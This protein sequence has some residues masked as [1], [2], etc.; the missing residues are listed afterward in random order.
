MARTCGLRNQV[1]GGPESLAR[2][3]IP[4]ETPATNQVRL[5][6]FKPLTCPRCGEPIDRRRLN[7]WVCPS[8]QARIGIAHSYQR[9]VDLLTFAWIV[10]L[11][12]VTHRSASDGTWLLGI[13]LSAIPFWIAFIVL[14][15]PWLKQGSNQPRVT[16]V[17]SF[18][19][20]AM[21]IFLVEFLGFTAVI[22]LL[23]SKRDLQEHLDMLSWPLAWINPNFLIT[24]DK[25]LSDVCG[26]ILGNSFFFGLLLFAC[27][28][29]VRWAFRRARVQRLWLSGTNPTDDDD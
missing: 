24:P 9:C 1:R 6:R 11:G 26:V 10:L 8:C 4:R 16:I 17:S 23:G 27:Y 22:L 12:I 5:T 19:G 14:V 29:A 7:E 18:L 2:P 25:A 20:A 28:Q 21:T 15:P 13:I 3:E